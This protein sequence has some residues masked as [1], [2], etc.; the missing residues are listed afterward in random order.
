M[1]KLQKTAVSALV[2]ASLSIAS[3]AQAVIVLHQI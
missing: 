1:K 3:A 2:L